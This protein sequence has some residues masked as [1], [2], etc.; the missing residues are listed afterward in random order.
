MKTNLF[1]F[2]I[3]LLN[4][5][6]I[7]SLNIP[8]NILSEEDDDNSSPSSIQKEFELT[9]EEI[10]SEEN[11]EEIFSPYKFS[12]EIF[13]KG[14][15]VFDTASFY[16][17]RNNLKKTDI[18]EYEYKNK[19]NENLKGTLKF[20]D[21]NLDYIEINSNKYN[22]YFGAIC[23]PKNIPDRIKEKMN[24]DNDE[25]IKY[26]YLDLIN[27]E[28]K[29]N[30]KYINYIQDSINTGK[31]IFGKK[32]DIFDEEKS[33]K[34]I[35]S[36]S[37][38]S[39][40]DTE[41]E[42]EF[43]N[44]WNCKIDSFL[45]N[46]IKMPSSYSTSING[47]IYAIFAI[48][49]EYIIAPK[50]TGTEI[51]NF[52]KDLI[53][54]NYDTSCALEMFSN[55]IKIMQ[56]KSF[57]FAELPDFNIILDGEI[58]LI[59]LS[60]DLFKEKND[61]HVYFKILLNQANTREYWYLGDPIIKN[62]N[63]LFDYTT[64]GKESITIVQSD[65]YESMIIILFFCISSF[66]TLL[67]YIF[68]IILRLRKMNKETYEIKDKDK[69]RQSRKI[70]NIIKNQNDFEI[71]KENITVEN[72]IKINSLT[73]DKI[74]ERSDEDEE[75]NNESNNSLYSNKVS[76]SFVKHEKDI[77]YQTKENNNKNEIEMVNIE[78]KS[79]S[80]EEEDESDLNA[81]DE[82]GIQPFNHTKLKKQ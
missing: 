46:S 55:D 44:F 33:H 73:S 17:W 67:F 60:F 5:F 30:E 52:Y 74:Q 69:R 64:P 61:T 50:I 11:K 63:L 35:K 37:C 12:S 40:K 21:L 8:N 47:D 70:K 81:D 77:K 80:S 72:M 19:K 51:I 58:Y 76:K 26:S 31:M 59:A 13:A 49:E 14:D 39:P 3:L 57:N 27:S 45:V 6:Y 56:C 71:P 48:E 41:I 10:E 28:L 18:G 24:P 75:S 34:E 78:G 79:N 25:N 42:N 7:K 38:I 23:I 16:S 43:L 82:G 15:Y 66:I 54:D 2:L 65:K 4:F 68:L 22:D 9:R 53:E 62:Y 1:Q 32:N 20:N 36:C 29:N